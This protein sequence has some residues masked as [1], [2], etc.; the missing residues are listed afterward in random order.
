MTTSPQASQEK[1]AEEWQWLF[2]GETT[3]GW[4]GFRQKSFPAKGWVVEDGCLKHQKDGGGGD[5]VT[6]EQYEN[7]ELSF[8]WR[9]GPGANSGIKYLITEDRSQ[10]VGIE[11]QLWDQ[12]RGRTARN[13]APGIH[14]TAA[15]YDLLAPSNADIKIDGQ[16]NQSR[17]IVQGK[18]VE[19]WLNG[20]RVLAFE[21]ESPELK[22]AIAKSKFKGVP[23]FGEKIRAHILLQD[24]GGE[25]WFRQLKIRR[26]PEI[27]K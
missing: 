2:Q 3:A 11:Y 8:E 25:V 9:L 18:H 23:G 10:A 15:A 26:L 5:L 12:T 16:F 7:F 13:E 6:V 14:S 19:H 21:L 4:R 17:I 24:H 27:K 1:A 22:A 20:Q